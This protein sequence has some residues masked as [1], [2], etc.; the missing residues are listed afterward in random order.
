M[1]SSDM[2][3]TSVTPICQLAEDADESNPERDNLFII[4]ECGKDDTEV[5]K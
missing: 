3:P 5:R 1:S 2:T 4:M